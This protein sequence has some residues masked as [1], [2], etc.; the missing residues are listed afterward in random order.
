M[1]ENGPSLKDG[2]NPPSYSNLDSV[3]CIALRLFLLND[4]FPDIVFAKR[5]GLNLLN[6][7]FTEIDLFGFVSKEYDQATPFQLV[8]SRAINL[9]L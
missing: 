7:I 1:N 5:V 9:Y 6:G 8:S 2:L 4:K 3:I